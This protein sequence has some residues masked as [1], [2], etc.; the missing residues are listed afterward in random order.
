MP[1]DPELHITVVAFS[2]GRGHTFADE[3]ALVKAALL[4]ADRVTLASPRASMYLNAA[5]YLTASENDRQRIVM[6]MVGVLPQGAGPA[7]V[8]EALLGKRGK[9]REELIAAG[10]G[11]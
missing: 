9:T 4:Y 8:W 7:A 3:L 5:S 6:Q 10:K 1:K 11:S 2:E